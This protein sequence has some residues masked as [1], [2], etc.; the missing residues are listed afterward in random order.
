MQ[1][2]RQGAKSRDVTQSRTGGN[3]EEN[4]KRK[5]WKGGGRGNLLAGISNC[6]SPRQNL[7]DSLQHRGETQ[8][9]RVNRCSKNIVTLPEES[10]RQKTK[11]KQTKRNKTKQNERRGK[12]FSINKVRIISNI[13]MHFLPLTDSNS[14][15]QRYTIWQ[16]SSRK[17]RPT[18]R[19]M[20]NQREWSRNKG[21][22]RFEGP[23]AICGSLCLCFLAFLECAAERNELG[24][25]RGCYA[26]RLRRTLGWPC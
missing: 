20:G 13:E 3:R 12:K 21:M 15:S 9:Q 26:L 11:P 17:T 16:Q 24:I 5:A 4:K 10:P 18:N 14:K 6:K 25:W 19:Q 22:G 2:A 1:M 8:Q 7:F 23:T